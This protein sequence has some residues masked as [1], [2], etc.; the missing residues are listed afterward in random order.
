MGGGCYLPFIYDNV[1][2]GHVLSHGAFVPC[3]Q[4]PAKRRRMR[5]PS[6]W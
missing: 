6:E 5:G 1:A 3:V 4:D 2:G